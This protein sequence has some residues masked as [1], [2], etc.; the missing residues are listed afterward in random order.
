MCIRDSIYTP[1]GYSQSGNAYPV[2]YLIPDGGS[3]YMSWFKDGRVNNIFDNL[4]ASGDVAP[5]ILV[6]VERTDVNGDG[7]R[8]YL[9]D[10]IAWVEANYNVAEGAQNRSLVGVSMGS[11]AATQIWL[12]APEQFGYYGFLSGGDKNRCKGAGQE[13][14]AFAY[15]ELDAGLLDKLRATT[16]FLGGGSSDFNM[17]A[18]DENSASVTDLDAWMTHYEIVHNGNGDGH[19]DV[20]AGDHNWP[21]WMKLMM[22]CASDYLWK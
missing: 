15:E 20:T 12:E 17:Y 13:G 22:T 9:R 21:I 4:I 6:S 1:A 19:Y 8:S 10:V 14:A 18:G 5:T 7:G 16:C 3:N 11:V 2:V